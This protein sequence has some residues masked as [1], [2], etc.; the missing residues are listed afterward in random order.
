M[1][2][3]RKRGEYQWEVQIRKKG[4]PEQRKTFNTKPEAEA[5]AAVIE[6]EMV[7]GVFV[8]RAEAERT[9]LG[10]I[11]DR[12]INEVTPTH[13]GEKSEEM[14][15]KA[16]RRHPLASRFL[17]SLTSTDF[18]KYRDERLKGTSDKK[19][20]KPATVHRE[21]GL[22]QQVIDQA[23]REYEISLPE[24]PLR[25][26]SRPKFQNARDRRLEAG[27]EK[28]LIAALESGGR[29]EEGKFVEGTRNPWVAPAV[30]LAIETAMRQGE[31]ISLAWDNIN[32][33]VATAH[34]PKTKNGTARTVPLSIKAVATLRALPRSIDGRVFPIT[35]NAL[36]IVWQRALI[37]AK[38]DYEKDCEKAGTKPDPCFLLNI[39]FHTLRHEAT[40]RLALKLSNILEL[41]SVTGHKDLQMVKRYYHPKAE[42]LA[43]KLG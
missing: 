22:F 21:L 38:K 39:T 19:S 6:S 2:S 29:D 1:A 4:F 10:Q 37:R 33:D 9:T 16:M 18:A 34:L 13:R 31:I 42:D 30:K 7:R 25:L 8:S 32:L 11:I 24:N 43:L 26:V 40:S 12:Y 23:R 27:E 14:R 5:W 36:K 20:V 15:L 41:A 17:A 3:I 28:Y 35:Q